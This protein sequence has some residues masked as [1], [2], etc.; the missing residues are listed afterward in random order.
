MALLDGLIPQTIPKELSINTGNNTTRD[1]NLLNFRG[2]VPISI[3]LQPDHIILIKIAE[4]KGLA[5][6]LDFLFSLLFR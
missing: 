1:L 6:L 3:S 4:K 2:K 5:P